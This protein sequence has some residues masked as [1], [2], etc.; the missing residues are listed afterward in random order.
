MSANPFELTLLIPSSYKDLSV[1]R[2]LRS[3]ASLSWVGPSGDTGAIFSDFPSTPAKSLEDIEQLVARP[4]VFVKVGERLI[5]NNVKFSRAL[6][7]YRDSLKESDSFCYCAGKVAEV[8]RYT[9]CPNR[10]CLSIC[11]FV[12]NPCLQNTGSAMSPIQLYE[13]AV[14]AEVEW[15][16]NFR[17]LK[18]G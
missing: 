6:Q 15:C 16:P 9:Q 3:A 12:C 18:G 1:T 11:S 5:P 17:S 13:A 7:C 10:R 2:E 14:R 4:G 8:P